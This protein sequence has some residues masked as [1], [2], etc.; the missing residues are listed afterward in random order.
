MRIIRL[1]CILVACMA[2]IAVG[3]WG[4]HEIRL[5]RCLDHGGRWNAETAA[6]E[7]LPPR[8]QEN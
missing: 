8:T 6:C 1:L 7:G 4:M 2:S 3:A 5:D